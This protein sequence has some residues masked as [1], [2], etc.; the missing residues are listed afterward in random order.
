MSHASIVLPL[1]ASPSAS[2]MSQASALLREAAARGRQ[3][4]ADRQSG[5]AV[6]G[7]AGRQSRWA[8]LGALH[9]HMHNTATTRTIAALHAAQQQQ[10]PPLRPR[11]RQPNRRT[12]TCVWRARPALQRRD[13]PC[14]RSPRRRACA[15]RDGGTTPTGRARLP[16]RDLYADYVLSDH[17]T[18][19]IALSRPTTLSDHPPPSGWTIRPPSATRCRGAACAMLARHHL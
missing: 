19:Q 8:V 17:P 1:V 13:R 7:A 12:S 5:Y 15:V 3:S 11:G 4:E 9:V 18:T 14:R 16:P 10:R 2:S 6:L